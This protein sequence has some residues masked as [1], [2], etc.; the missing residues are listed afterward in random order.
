MSMDTPDLN[1]PMKAQDTTNYLLGG[2]NAK[3]D[4]VIGNQTSYE[5]RLR[6]VESVIAALPK[7]SPWFAIVGGVSG[8][9][10]IVLSAITLLNIL[11]P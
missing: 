2:L 4:I 7:R 1:P 11:N 9:G 3:L 5:V 10:A 6:D 8:I